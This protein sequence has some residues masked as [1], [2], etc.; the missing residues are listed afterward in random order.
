[1]KII[2]AN[3]DWSY[4]FDE[5]KEKEDGLRQRLLEAYQQINALRKVEESGS[6]DDGAGME[7]TRKAIDK[8]KKAL[9]E[10]EELIRQ[11]KSG[12]A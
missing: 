11:R 8:Y 10:V 4:S 12:T 1:M 6:V 5:L 9:G 7:H 3:D 2:F